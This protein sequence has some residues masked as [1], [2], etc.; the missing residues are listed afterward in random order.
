MKLN[1]V[2][3]LIDRWI[4]SRVAYLIVTN[5]GLSLIMCSW[6]L[7]TFHFKGKVIGYY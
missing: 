2:N 3:K 4:V 6:I 7:V 1:W 5:L